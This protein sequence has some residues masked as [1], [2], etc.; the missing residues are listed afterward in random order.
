[1]TGVCILLWFAVTIALLIRHPDEFHKE[2]MKLD[3]F[4]KGINHKSTNHK[5]I[6]RK[7]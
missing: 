1:M 2:L 4:Y 7:R 5:G 3:P 6:N